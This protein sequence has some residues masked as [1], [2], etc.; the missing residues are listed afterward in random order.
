MRLEA[1]FTLLEVLLALTVFALIVSI[2]YT[3]LGP[4]GEGFK[5]LQEVRDTLEESSW[6]GRQLRADVGA[7]T[8]SSL[9]SLRPVAIKTDTRGDVHVDELFLLVR[10][11]GHRGLSQVHYVFDEASGEL[12]RESRMAW[13]REH[14]EVDRM[15]LAHI[16]SFDVTWMNQQGQWQQIWPEM[17]QGNQTFVWP[18]A[19]RVR[20]VQDGKQ[21]EWL[22]PL[23]LG[24]V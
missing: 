12:R 22:L 11:A 3:A 20:V 19:L 21:R 9:K 18:K 10:E 2:S 8:S 17:R 4:A 24:Q 13:A 5:Q 16:T 6:L 23:M 1:G 14:V 7:I 15:V